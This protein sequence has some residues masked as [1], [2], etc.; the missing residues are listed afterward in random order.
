MSDLSSDSQN[1]SK[2]QGLGRGLGS[3]LGGGSGSMTDFNQPTKAP[4]QTPAPPAPAPV[5]NLTIQTTQPAIRP[6]VPP[7]MRIWQVSI[8]KLV[9]GEYQPRQTFEKERLEELAQSIRESGILQPVVAKKLENGKFEIIAGERRWRAAQ[10]AGLHTVP[11]ILK[12]LSQQK[13]LEMALIENIQRE[14]LNAIEEAEAYQRL[15]TEF[16]LTQQQMSEKLGKDRATIANSVRLLNLPKLIQTMLVE[17][18][19]SPGHAKLLVSV[20]D[21]TKQLDLAKQVERDKLSVRQLEKLVSQKS[22]A[23]VAIPEASAL[24][25]G[26]T[27]RLIAGLGEELQKMLG[28]KVGIDY[29]QGKGK[30]AIHFYSDEELTDIVEKIKSGCQK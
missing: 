24:G 23:V 13:T 20:S 28:T 7:E 2:K 12:T 5:S 27:Q 29:A 9:S 14:D 21:L 3:L 22:T 15:M 16:N 25:S 26:V 10:L 4:A 8:D 19:L 17:K 11:V 18:R 1:K 30:I 6:E